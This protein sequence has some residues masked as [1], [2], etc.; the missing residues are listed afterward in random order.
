MLRGDRSLRIE[1]VHRF[2]SSFDEI[3]QR[4]M[5]WSGFWSPHNA[6]FLN[7]RYFGDPSSDYVA[8]ALLSGS[9]VQG[10]YVLKI[11][12]HANW[13]MEFV[14]PSSPQRF[15]STLLLHLIATARE[16]GCNR[17]RFWSPPGWHHWKLQGMAGFLPVR[18]QV[19]LKTHPYKAE[20]D[21]LQ[22]SAWQFVSG[23]TDF[24]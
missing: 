2:E 24:L 17:I 18:S 5:A 22:L 23:D 13:L 20:L 4:C 11:D 3:T 12:G 21:S 10:Y 16:A 1:A 6:E 9:E 15:A 7:W 14:A 8:F 19:Y